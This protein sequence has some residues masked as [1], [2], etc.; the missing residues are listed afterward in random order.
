ML[1]RAM[2]DGS[3][4]DHQGAIRDGLGQRADI[5]GRLQHVLR[6]H[7]GAGFAKRDVVRIHQPQFGESEIAH[8][9]RGGAD[10]QRIARRHQDHAERI[11]A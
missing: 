2:A 8:G 1:Q 3:G 10:V 5:R 9:A 6:L 4:A 7:G 11:T